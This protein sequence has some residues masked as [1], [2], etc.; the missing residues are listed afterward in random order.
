MMLGVASVSICQQREMG[1]SVID[2]V[3]LGS[4]IMIE[5]QLWDMY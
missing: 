2:A 1:S 5:S 4:Y 3:S